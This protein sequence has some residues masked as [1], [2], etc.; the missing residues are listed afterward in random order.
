MLKVDLSDG[1]YRIR[2]RPEDIPT[3]GV[4]FPTAPSERKLVAFPLTLPMGWTESPPYFCSATETIADLANTYAGSPWDPTL[5]HLERHA[6]TH[7]SFTVSSPKTAPMVSL[8]PPQHATIPPASFLHA[9]PPHPGRIH[10]RHR[11][12]AYADV[13]V[14]DEILVGQGSHARLNRFRR[15]LLHLNDAVFRPNDAMDTIRKEPISLKKLS[16]GDACWSPRKVILGWQV[17]TI[18]GTLE[19]PAHRKQRLLAILHAVQGRKRISLRQMH[20]L[21]GELRSMVLGVPGGQGLFSHLQVALTRCDHHRVKLHAEAQ[22][23]IADFLLLAHDLTQR[24]TRLTELF[25]ATPPHHVGACDAALPGMGGVWLPGPADSHPPLVWR[26]PFAPSV[27]NNLVSQSHPTGTVTNS[28]LELAGTI[29][30]AAVL[31]DHLDLRECTLAI[32]SDNTPTIAW[33]GKGSV[34]TPGPASYLLRLAALHQRAHRYV[35]QHSHLPGP[36]NTLADIAS[37]RFDLTP[38]QLLSHLDHIAPHSQPWSMLSLPHVT[39]LQLT[40][41]L[42]RQRPAWPSLKTAPTRQTASGLTTG[43]PIPHRWASTTPSSA[44]S[45]TKFR[46]SGSWPTESVTAAPVAATNRSA[47]N[48]YVTKYWLSPRRSPHWAARIPASR[49]LAPWTPA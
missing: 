32:C 30:H 15:Q 6:A 48:A 28:D 19:L 2:L 24:P 9:L 17:D 29:A 42:H 41:A 40:T 34:T 3:L 8:P 11:P 14:D 23:A 36:A 1:F 44:T 43:F 12:L 27:Q 37:R 18:A 21:L 13:F 46:Y 33:Q 10:T 38:D 49:L 45:M 4:A 16:Q 25:P 31:A 5:H 26:Q 7:P 20:Q 35:L 47:L 22:H 39:H